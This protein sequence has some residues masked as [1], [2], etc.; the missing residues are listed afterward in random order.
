[1]TENTSSI[2]PSTKRTLG[3]VACSMIGSAAMTIFAPTTTT[4]SGSS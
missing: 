2:I 3:V 1:M 4:T